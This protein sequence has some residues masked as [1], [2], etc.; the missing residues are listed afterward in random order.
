M[1][2]T[3]LS[4]VLATVLGL[5]ACTT[6]NNNTETNSETSTVTETGTGTEVEIEIP[7]NPVNIKLN[8]I[9]EIIA[10]MTL[11]EKIGQMVQGEVRYI[12]VGDIEKY[13][14]GSVLNGGGIPFPFVLEDFQLEDWLFYADRYYNE[15]ISKSNGRMGIPTMWGTDAVHGHSNAVGATVFPHNIGLGAANNPELM[16][17]IGEITAKEV[18]VTGV[19][20]TFAP[21]L[22][23]VRDDHWGRTY[24]SFSEDPSI[25]ANLAD[26]IVIGLQGNKNDPDNFLNENRIIATAKHFVGDGGT[27]NGNDRDE[28]FDSLED[29]LAI[30]G[31]GY[32]VSID[33][34]VQ[35]VM[36]SYSSALGE[37][38]HGNKYLLTDVL[39]DEM[40]FE[41]FV[42][43]DWEGH[44]EVIGCDLSSCPQAINAGI[45]MFM[46][47]TAWKDFIAG[48][49]EDVNEGE[50]SIDRINEAVKRILTVKK[51]MGLFDQVQPSE[52]A[53]SGQAKFLGSQEHRDVAR[54]AV[55]ESLV[56]LKNENNI[57]PL[58]R[59]QNVLVAGRSA[60][61]MQNQHG[62]W[63]LTW[64]G[65][66][67]W[68][69]HDNSEY[70][71][72]TTIYSGIKQAVESSGGSASFSEYA[73]YDASN[74]PDVVIYVFGEYPYA[75][76][77]GDRDE[78]GV[79]Y[80]Q[81][82]TTLEYD[83]MY[84]FDRDIIKSLEYEGIPVVGIFV[85]GRPMIINEEIENSEAFV[86]A[87]LPGSEG[88]GVAEVLFKNDAD[89]INY[90]FKGKL[91]YSWP[92]S[93]LDDTPNVGDVNYDPLYEFGYGLTY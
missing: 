1:K 77:F 58:S 39:R 44:A 24:E 88:S 26:D 29:L 83:T 28:N 78:E 36:V 20:W 42:I 75:E 49:I 66:N 63:T 45:D 13:H 72:A 84:K 81:D 37:K 74:K 60:D 90:N 40:G 76:F 61:S 64:Q 91:S 48:T 3:Q 31:A 9:D 52:R 41:G 18:R 65:N 7:N 87:W 27:L 46:V 53:L 47:P 8:T 67:Y 43:G 33:A 2:K 30:H 50:V 57:L 73:A 69:G 85:S 21:T 68:D 17:R 92:K 22:A 38:M 15:S 62:G 32:P 54:Q 4:I 35:T 5:N 89:E 93:V 6:N 19:D 34:G 59:N 12:A 16:E 23:V 70:V 14:L 56:L 80:G 79:Y 51:N 86:A 55:R 82:G 25:V 11:E 71:G 10:G